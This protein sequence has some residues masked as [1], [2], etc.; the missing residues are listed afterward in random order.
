MMKLR[1]SLEERASSAI[2]CSVSEPLFDLSLSP[3]CSLSLVSTSDEME[4]IQLSAQSNM[5][6]HRYIHGLA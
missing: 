6:T 3:L 1:S 2:S 5:Y 4:M